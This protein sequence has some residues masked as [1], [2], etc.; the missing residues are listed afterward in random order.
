MR[1]CQ[2]INGKDGCSI[3]AYK[4]R[5]SLKAVDR[6]VCYASSEDKIG[7][8]QAMQHV[9]CS[10]TCSK[11]QRTHDSGAMRFD[12]GHCSMK[13]PQPQPLN[14]EHTDGPELNSC[15]P[16]RHASSSRTLNSNA[17]L[18]DHSNAGVNTHA[19]VDSLML[20]E[21]CIASLQHIQ[22]WPNVLQHEIAKT[23]GISV[24]S[25]QIT[26]SAQAYL[27]GMEAP[28]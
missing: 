18:C 15:T 10:L 17:G 4:G 21:S 19:G 28:P 5:R 20:H 27:V 8:S 9:C 14:H 11:D 13:V 23:K 25:L 7:T 6:Q 3:K 1:A 16:C 22:C 26:R 24:M 12:L 2:N